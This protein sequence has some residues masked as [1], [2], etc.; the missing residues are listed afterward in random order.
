MTPIGVSAIYML[1]PAPARHSRARSAELEFNSESSFGG[2]H[3]HERGAW[4]GEPGEGRCHAHSQA[5]RGPGK[6]HQ[7]RSRGR[8]QNPEC[9]VPPS[10]PHAQPARHPRWT[11]GGERGIIPSRPGI[12]PPGI[13]PRI[14][15]EPSEIARPREDGNQTSCRPDRAIGSIRGVGVCGAGDT[16]APPCPPSTRG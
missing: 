2:E 8:P 15:P 3:A 13:S 10:T 1:A 6:E 14:R 4:R 11:R 5:T 9:R 12:R 7:A 16:A